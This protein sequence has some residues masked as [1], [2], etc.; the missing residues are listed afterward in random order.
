MHVQLGGAERDYLLPW[1]GELDLQD[2][3]VGPVL[4]VRLDEQGLRYWDWQREPW[5]PGSVVSLMQPRLVPSS[6]GMITLPGQGMRVLLVEDHEVN[7]VLIS[8][9]L[10][11]LGPG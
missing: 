6:Q 3:P 4:S 8:M 2:D 10:T 1:L 11:Q 5:V 7:R 9:Q